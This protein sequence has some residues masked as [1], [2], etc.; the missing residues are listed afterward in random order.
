MKLVNED[1]SINVTTF[2]TKTGKWQVVGTESPSPNECID[3]CYNRSTGERIKRT[4]QELRELENKGY[5]FN[6]G[7]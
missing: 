6:V 7:V 5:I 2:Y 3:E 4:R 1:G